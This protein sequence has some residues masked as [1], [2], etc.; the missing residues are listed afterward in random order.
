MENNKI[1][2][3]IPSEDVESDEITE[4]G[5]SKKGTKKKNQRKSRKWMFFSLIIIVAIIAVMILRV[6]VVFGDYEVRATYSRSD[7]EETAY[8][9]FNNNLLK[10]SPDGASY[11]TFT[12][13]TIWT[14]TYDMTSP[15]MANCGDYI[16]IYDAKGN[17]ADLFSTTGFLFSFVMNMNI[18]DADVAGNGVV[19]LLLN[20]NG[21]GYIHLYN[22]EGQLAA[23]GELDPGNSGYALDTALSSDGTNLAISL[24][25]LNGGN[26]TT[27]INIY[28]FEEKLRQSTDHLIYQYSYADAV[29]PEIDYVDSDRLLAIGDKEIAIFKKGAGS[30]KEIFETQKM[31][32]VFH[33]DSYVGII[34]DG[35]NENGQIVDVMK[36]YGLYGNTLF[37][38]ELDFSYENIFMMDNDEIVLTNS[39][40]ASIY[41][42]FGIKKFSTTF[43]GA[44]YNIIPSGILRNYYIIKENGMDEIRLIGD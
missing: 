6:V 8:F 30:E 21:K 41:S 15:K 4:N 40:S 19:S 3:Y 1:T 11:S 43:D 35:I 14:Y 18:T 2:L 16:V 29:F 38:K 37:T 33:N 39:K 26:V 17:E 31:K 12:G 22:K 10:Y 34:I 23:S 5:S 24:I 27:D 44:V 7:T 28:S 25:N 32:S 36:L 9:E 20:D 13:D 42:K